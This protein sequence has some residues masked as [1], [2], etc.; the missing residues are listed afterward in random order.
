MFDAILFGLRYTLTEISLLDDSICDN[1]FVLA[2]LC[3]VC[4]EGS[5]N[6]PICA[7]VIPPL[8][9]T[10]ALSAVVVSIMW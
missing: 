2:E 5:K 3:N 6:R 10:A 4:P 8:V 9:V 7:M 1:F